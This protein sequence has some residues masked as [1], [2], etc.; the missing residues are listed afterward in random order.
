M[1]VYYG[2][3]PDPSVHAGEVA[4]V[5]TDEDVHTL[6]VGL[7]AVEPHSAVRQHAN[8]LFAQLKETQLS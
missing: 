2:V 8:R 1:R 3:R 5:L 7:R 6:L 4:V